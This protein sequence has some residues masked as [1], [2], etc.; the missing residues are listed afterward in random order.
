MFGQ[1]VR[2]RGV[3]ARRLDSTR[4]RATRDA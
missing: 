3:A 2:A 4:G 1:T